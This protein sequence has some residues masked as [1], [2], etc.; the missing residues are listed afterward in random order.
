LA[1]LLSWLF[2]FGE[3]ACEFILS[4]AKEVRPGF[5]KPVNPRELIPSSVESRHR[6]SM[7][8]WYVYIIEKSGKLYVGITTDLENRM[9]QHEQRTPLYQEGRMSKRDALKRERT[10]KGWS[11][12][13]KLDLIS[14]PSSQPK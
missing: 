3:T 9:R 2:V 6:S 1:P 14:K 10:I 13:K 8:N 5:Q 12:K 7:N 11:R 4:G